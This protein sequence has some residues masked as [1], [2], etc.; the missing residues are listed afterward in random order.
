MPVTDASPSADGPGHP[1][2]AWVRDWHRTAFLANEVEHHREWTERTLRHIIH[3]KINRMKLEIAKKI[4]EPLALVLSK[5]G[6]NTEAISS[7]STAATPDLA[8][9]TARLRSWESVATPT[10]SS[11][12]SRSSLAS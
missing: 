7:L 8:P 1:R 10:P 12:R 3:E 9:S 11:G 2:M 4:V 6:A 5:T